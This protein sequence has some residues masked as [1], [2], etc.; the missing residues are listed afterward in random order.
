L[1]AIKNKKKIKI[2]VKTTSNFAGGIPD[3]HSSEFILIDDKY[4][5]VADYLYVLRIDKKNNPIQLDIISK[6]EIDSFSDSHK[7]V[8]RIRTTK[9]DRVLNKREIGATIMLPSKNN[10]K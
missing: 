10:K 7:L 9:L 2:E 3:M 6:K 8:E 1:I 4:F 5:F